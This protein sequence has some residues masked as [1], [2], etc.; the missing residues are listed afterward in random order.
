[1][2]NQLSMSNS[3]DLICNSIHLIDSNEMV[4]IRDLFI[5]KDEASDIVGIPPET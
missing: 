3:R 2:L 5:T 4:N 1:M